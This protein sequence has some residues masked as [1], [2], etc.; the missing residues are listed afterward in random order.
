MSATTT[1]LSVEFRTKVQQAIIQ[2]SSMFNTAKQQATNL[3][4]RDSVLSR[5][6]KGELEGVLSREKWILISKKLGAGNESAWKTAKTD[7]F[8]YLYEQF[9][10]CQATAD[11]GILCDN[12]GIGKTYTA[13]CYTSEHRNAILIDCSRTKKRTQFIRKIAQEFGLDFRSSLAKVYENLC[14]YLQ[15]SENPFIIL[16][17]AGDLSYDAFLE[18]KGLWNASENSCGWYMLGADGLRKKMEDKCDKIWIGYPEI[19][20][21][22][23]SR[24]QQITPKGLA[25]KEDFKKREFAIVAKAN[26]MTGIQKLYAYSN[27]SIGRLKREFNKGNK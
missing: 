10:M 19:F 13:K 3:D 27:G 9:T 23:G 15:T 26:G 18:I 1:T 11:S 12:T 8:R 25:S 7:T 16:D 6:K 14:D 24:Y 5:I 2:H 20:R 17:E 22:F 4:I 21:R